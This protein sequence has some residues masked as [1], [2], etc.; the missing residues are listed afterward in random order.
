[1]KKTNYCKKAFTLIELLVV[2]AVI[3]FLTSVAFMTFSNSREKAVYGRILSDFESISKAVQLYRTNSSDSEY[4]VSA[5]AGNM[6]TGLN[7]YMQVWPTPPCTGWK[8]KWDNAAVGGS[9]VWV[10]DSANVAKY[11]YCLSG[12]CTGGGTGIKTIKTVTCY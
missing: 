9:Q 8:Y 1:M 10:Q 5:T 11:Y 7:T 12:T 6:P 2:I 4:P 3:G